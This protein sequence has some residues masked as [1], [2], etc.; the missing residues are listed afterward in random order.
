MANSK[1]SMC[2]VRDKA[3]TLAVGLMLL[4]QFCPSQGVVIALKWKLCTSILMSEG[5]RSQFQVVNLFDNSF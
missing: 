2:F 1:F 4:K 5:D 3:Q